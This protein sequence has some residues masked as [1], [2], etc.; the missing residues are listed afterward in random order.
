MKKKI[1]ACLLAASLVVTGVNVSNL[2]IAGDSTR[3]EAATTDWG[4]TRNY[5]SGVTAT[6]ANQ[7]SPSNDWSGFDM[8]FT[9]NSG[10]TICDWIVVLEVPSGTASAFK[11]WNATFV[12]D[13]DTIYMY[14][15]QNGSNAVAAPGNMVNNAPGGGFVSTYVDASN[16]TVKAVYYNIGTQSEY[17]YSSGETNDD[18]SGGGGSSSTD[19]D[20]ST[21]KDLVVEYNYAKALQES[22]YFYDANMCGTGVDE[23]CGLSWRGD[24]HTEDANVSVSVNGTTYQVDVSGGFHDA[25]DH[26]KFGQPQGYAA[27]ALGMSYYEFKDAYTELGQTE[28]LKTITNYFCDYLKR[29]TVYSDNVNKTGGVVAFCYQVGEGNADHGYWGAPENQ[30]GTRPAYFATASNPATDEVS[31]AVAAL[32]VNYLNFG[33]VEDLKVAKDLFTFVQNN[34]KSCATE[35]PGS[36]YVSSSWKDDY[37]TAAAALYKATGEA[38]YQ[39]EYNNNSAGGGINTGWMLDWDN[40]G[41]MAAMLMEDWTK[42]QA[43]ANTK[44]N[45]TILDGVYNCISDWGSCRYN[46]AIQFCGLVYDKGNGGDSY[47][48][49]AE[50]QMR[51]IIGENPN[52]RCY[53]VGYNE[54]SAKYPHHRAAS[55]SSNAGEVRAD[56]YI[57]LGALVGGPKQN[58][59]YVDDQND[60][61]CNEVA[62]DYNVGLVCASAGLYL[63]TKGSTAADHSETLATAEEL[64]ALNITKYYSSSGVSNQTPAPQQSSQPGQTNAPQQSSQP[65]QSTAPGQSSQP[66]QTNVPNHSSQPGQTAKPGSSSLPGQTSVPNEGQLSDDENKED[67]VA[68]LAKVKIKKVTSGKKQLTVKWKK[69][70]SAGGYQMVVSKKK[71]MKKGKKITVKGAKKTKKVIKKLSSK[72]KYY[73]RIRAWKKIDGKKAYGAWSKVKSKKTK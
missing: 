42:L 25:G 29:S 59:T 19:V 3:V 48:S 36:F 68:K 13:G 12:A 8:T 9:N 45:G 38:S 39:Q 23:N 69:V 67:T 30:T 24:C 15:M 20:T 51:Y 43:I 56:H 49:W 2:G 35:G 63:A 5:S 57:L 11:C 47:T 31:I 1:L 10:N 17:D 71:N 14:P 16:I 60:F 22:L 58:G 53:I 4:T 21:N 62:L 26:V 61:I 50:S 18:N 64:A 72:K 28:H 41:A 37:V 54:N 34:S 7:G 65:A 44:S 70:K 27:T 33:N 66:G 73:V 32:A 46:A 40:S 52:K 6:V 55:R